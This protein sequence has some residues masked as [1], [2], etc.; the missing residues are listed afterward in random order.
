MRWRRPDV[1]QGVRTH[2]STE[3]HILII[4]QASGRR[5]GRPDGYIGKI[6]KTLNPCEASGHQD[7][8]SGRIKCKT[9]FRNFPTPRP[10][11]GHMVSGRQHPIFSFFIPQMIFSRFPNTNSLTLG[12]NKVPEGQ[13][14]LNKHSKQGG[15]NTHNQTSKQINTQGKHNWK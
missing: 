7:W 2:S 5:W 12:L 15:K 1:G 3:T 8:V 10:S 4:S 9:I 14:V 11:N 13:M 6:F